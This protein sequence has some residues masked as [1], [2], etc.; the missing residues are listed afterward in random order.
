MNTDRLIA[1]LATGEG[2]TLAFRP[3][4]R[5]ALAAA[6]GALC[7]IPVMVMMLGFNPDLAVAARLP[8]ACSERT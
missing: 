1:M 8:S 2:R 6:A 7:A 5:L 3:E 4:R